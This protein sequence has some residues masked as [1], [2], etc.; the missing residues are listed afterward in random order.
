MHNIH[1]HQ[2]L[3]RLIINALSRHKMSISSSYLLMP[4]KITRY[5]C[6]QI[7]TRFSPHMEEFSLLLVGAQ[8]T[9][10]P[11]EFSSLPR[12]SEVFTPIAQQSHEARNK[13]TR[14]KSMIT[15]THNI[16]DPR[17]THMH[18]HNTCI[19]SQHEDLPK[20]LLTKKERELNGS[21][22]QPS[23]KLWQCEL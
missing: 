4:P 12:V 5:P 2:A 14:R 1:Y 21:W 23:S 20:K 10:S 7:T 11:Q 8:L 22:N 9:P 16:Q 19:L 18:L 6:S 15:F 3:S 17:N 13:E